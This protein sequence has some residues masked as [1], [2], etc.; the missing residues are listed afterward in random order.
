MMEPLQAYGPYAFGV[1]SVVVLGKFAASLW[2]QIV[3][4]HMAMVEVQTNTVNQTVETLRD[5]AEINKQVTTELRTVVDDLKTMREHDKWQLN[6]HR[7]PTP[8]F[9]GH[10]P[11]T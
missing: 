11:G 5:T 10:T 2:K 4:P 8:P 6:N 9:T 3:V 1:V 7:I